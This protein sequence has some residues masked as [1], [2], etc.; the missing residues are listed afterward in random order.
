MSKRIALALIASSF[1]T[2]GCPGPAT[3][4]IDGGPDAP[5]RDVPL[6]DVPGADV[7]GADVPGLDVGPIDAPMPGDAPV[8]DDVPA[9]DAPADAPPDPCGNGTV[10]TG[11]DCDGTNLGGQDCAG[12]G[13]MGGTLA[14]RMDCTLD[15]TGCVPVMCGDAMIGGTEVCDGAAL[16]GATCV[17]RGF[18]GGTLACAV[19]CS[20]FDT[21]MCTN[22]GNGTIDTGEVCDGAALGGATCASR[23]YDTGVLSCGVGCGFFNEGMCQ[24]Y[25]PPM[26]G[27]VVITE[28]MPNPTT[29]GDA[30]GEWFEV[31]NRGSATVDLEGCTV[32]DNQMPPAVFTI[33]SD[34]I[35]APGARA[36]F[37]SS[38]A[39]GF[40][41]DYVYA[42]WPLA[43]TGDRIRILCGTTIVDDVTYTA[44]FP[45]AAGTAMQL[46]PTRIA[47]GMNDLPGDW[48]AAT[49]SYNGD[50][51]TPGGANRS[52]FSPEVCTGGMDEDGDGA[53]DCMDTDCALDVACRVWTVGF[54]RLQSPLTI[55][56]A[57]GA[58]TT[59]YGR[60]FVAGLTDASGVNDPHPRLVAAVGVG[61]DGSDPASAAGWTWTAAAPNAGYGP[62]SPG[63]EMNNDEYQADLAAP[64]PAGSYDYAYRFSGDGGATWLYCD[65]QP[66]GS[67][68]GYQTANAG[69]LTS[70]PAG[71]LV[72]LVINEVDYDQAGTDSNSFIEIYNGTGGPVALGNLTVYLINGG[73]NTDYASF[74]LLAA[75]ATLPAGGYLVIRN[76]TVAIPGGVLFVTAT[77][78]FIQ[79][80]M[81]DGVALVDTSTGRLVDA[82]S[83][84][85]SMTAVTIP[86]ITGTVSLVEGTAFGGADTNDNLNS[87]SRMPNG[88]DTNN[89]VADWMLRPPSP[90][91]A[92]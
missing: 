38:A 11:E 44:S 17:T 16:G 85:G 84:E 51:G 63:Y 81:P 19:D 64:G 27:E 24:N 71:S 56:A 32:E 25:D 37:A 87:L 35:L 41:P 18:F 70:T 8:P 92:N 43:N 45:F 26:A 77:G 90:G 7:P 12:L 72:G 82:L 58:P 36:T 62:A 3:P 5:S 52:C 68:D 4:P 79:N 76:N 6:A 28:V 10:D 59:V 23:G 89:A 13:F 74:P 69:Q 91:V 73:T 49:A 60:V 33:T 55:T 88:T 80:G 78:D 83:Y 67:S 48:C 46:D 39:P 66:A 1:A 40:T 29:V 31:Q 14:C 20:A 21:A 54:C 75:G 9:I 65:G 42:S 50:L 2:A 30:T 53:I 15:T 57:V 34:V 22:C 47:S 61:P 86:G